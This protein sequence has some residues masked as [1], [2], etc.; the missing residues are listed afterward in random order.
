[1]FLPVADETRVRSGAARIHVH[2]PLAVGAR[3]L[4]R[5]LLGLALMSPAYVGAQSALVGTRISGSLVYDDFPQLGNCFDPSDVENCRAPWAQPPFLPSSAI[6]P[7]AI[8]TENDSMY[9]ELLFDDQGFLSVAVDVD[10]TAVRIRV[11]NTSGSAA[12][13]APYGFR[14]ELEDLFPA[15]TILAAT[16]QSVADFPGLVANPTADGSGVE[17]HYPGRD[18]CPPQTANDLAILAAYNDGGDLAAEIELETHK[19]GGALEFEDFPQLGNCFDSA[20]ASA[21]RSP[22][23]M[24]PFAPDSGIQPQAELS[25]NDAFFPEFVLDD[26]E[27]LRT[28]VDVDT[29]SIR[30]RVVNQSG[31][32]AT[33][34]PHGFA[35]PLFD[36]AP[37]APIDVA[38]VL[39]PEEFPGLSVTVGPDRQSV[40]L[41]FAGRDTCPPSS[42]Q[43]FAILAALNDDSELVAD[44]AIGPRAIQGGLHFSDFPQLGNCFD[45]L[46]VANCRAPGAVPP[47]APS[48]G[49]QPAA[50]VSEADDDFSEFV[51]DDGGNLIIRADVDAESIRVTL[52]NT[53]QAPASCAPFGFDLPLR[54]LALPGS[55]VVAS[56][57]DAAD[58]PG[59]SVT[60]I[61]EGTGISIHFPGRDACPPE[62]ENDLQV[63]G[64]YNADGTL[65]GTL[66]LT[67]V[68]P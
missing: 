67:I 4:A 44:I 36:L 2:A 51:F 57:V 30:I 61:D 28:S 42:S 45:P 23:A 68:E 5:A 35:I 40:E 34:A 37:I 3:V 1:V 41:D 21:C 47:F 58:F 15:H 55:T 60:S 25:E 52:E 16:L 31:Q 48:S 65:E 19:I 9:P 50:I 13:C 56:V 29:Q 8:V 46:D 43:D 24:P 39:A 17:I 64:A 63:L 62:S 49:I 22:G 7:E 66:S 12:D 59:L 53:A 18:F 38:T 26:P 32:P 11:E 14:V 10:A 33:C 54:G 6:Q 20:N 27:F